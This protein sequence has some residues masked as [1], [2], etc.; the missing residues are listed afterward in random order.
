[1]KWNAVEGLHVPLPVVHVSPA[2]SSLL[3]DDYGMA[4]ASVRP[5]RCSRRDDDNDVHER[6]ILSS[7]LPGMCVFASSS[8]IVTSDDVVI[9]SARAIA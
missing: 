9:P 2:E 4:K 6:L 5:P 3:S 8:A 1:M 7:A